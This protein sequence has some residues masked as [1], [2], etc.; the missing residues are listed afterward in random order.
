[1]LFLKLGITILE[2]T[3]DNNQTIKITSMVPALARQ[4]G[5]PKMYLDLENRGVI[6]ETMLRQVATQVPTGFADTTVFAI[7][8][9]NIPP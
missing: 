7:D 2:A 3:V 8:P 4:I 6:N 5:S 9:T 1:M